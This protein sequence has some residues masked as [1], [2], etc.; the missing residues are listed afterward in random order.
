M[1]QGAIEKHSNKEVLAY[2]SVFESALST[3]PYRYQ[4]F[5]P[6]RKEDDPKPS[7]LSEAPN[8]PSTPRYTFLDSNSNF[9]FIVNSLLPNDKVNVLCDILNKYKGVIGYSINDL[10]GLSPTICMH[11]ILLED[12]TKPT[13][14]AQRRLNPTLKEVVRKKVIKLLDNEIIYSISNSKWVSLVQVV[15]KKGGLTVVQNEHNDLVPTRT[16]TGWRM[17]IDYRKL[18]KETRKDHFPLPFIDQVI[19]RLEI[20]SYFCYLDRLTG[21]YQIPINLE[22]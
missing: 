17:C 6:L 13:I 3:Y 2:V 5:E 21:F 10:K 15:P 1:S 22:D 7:S 19:E 14:E 11:R 20:F 12:D 9:P 16:I 18:N 8:L 4:R